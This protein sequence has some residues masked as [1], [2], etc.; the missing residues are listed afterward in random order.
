MGDILMKNKTTES[1]KRLVAVESAFYKLTPN[2][3][4][5]FI[6]RNEMWRLVDADNG[7]EDESTDPFPPKHGW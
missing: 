4:S 5:D 7:K 6:R 3:K 1:A 2:E